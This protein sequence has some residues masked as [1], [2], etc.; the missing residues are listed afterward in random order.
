[1]NVTG[2]GA[3]M[4]KPLVSFTSAY[5]TTDAG[6]MIDIYSELVGK[7]HFVSAVQVLTGVFLGHIVHKSRAGCLERLVSTVRRS[8]SNDPNR[9]FF[10]EPYSMQE[11]CFSLEKP[12]V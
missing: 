8:C 5:K 10:F 1:L 4:P 7:N 6:I 3:A 12:E 11:D 9:A 2:G